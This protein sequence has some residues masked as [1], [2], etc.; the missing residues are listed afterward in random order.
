MSKFKIV[1]DEEEIPKK[2]YNIN[3]DLPK[4]LSPPI[5][6]KTTADI[7]IAAYIPCGR[8]VPDRATKINPHEP[9]NIVLSG[10]VAVHQSDVVNTP[11]CPGGAE[12]PHV[13]F[14]WS[15]DEEGIDRVSTPV[16]GPVERV[17]EIRRDHRDDAQL[18]VAL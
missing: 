10:D 17:V 16:E 5:D 1:L 6:A 14:G 9:A 4:P 15:V 11:T 3:P 13:I 2:W 18:V 8:A 7:R 12:E